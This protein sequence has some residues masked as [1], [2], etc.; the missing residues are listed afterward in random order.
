MQQEDILDI[1][2]KQLVG[3]LPSEAPLVAIQNTNVVEGVTTIA[4]SIKRQFPEL[5]E[6]F[7]HNKARSIENDTEEENLQ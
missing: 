4:D 2:K 5:I 6:K 7:S 1:K 3:L